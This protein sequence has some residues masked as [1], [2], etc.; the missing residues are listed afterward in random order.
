LSETEKL[1]KKV[2]VNPAGGKGSALKIANEKLLPIMGEA[3][4]EHNLITTEYEGHGLEIVRDSN[5]ADLGSKFNK[6]LI[7]I[8][9]HRQIYRHQN[10]I[11]IFG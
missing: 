8:I 7:Q 6:K 3:D 4:I 11:A 10:K 5:L 2:L 9:N 1:T